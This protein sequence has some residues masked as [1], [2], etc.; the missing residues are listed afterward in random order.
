[1]TNVTMDTPR[2]PTTSVSGYD[3]T[4]APT[5]AQ[6]R[7]LEVFSGILAVLMILGPLAMGAWFGRFH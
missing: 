1:M 2:R 6:L 4:Q 3:G 7:S 5:D